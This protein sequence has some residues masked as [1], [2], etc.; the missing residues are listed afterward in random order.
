[1]SARPIS[2]TWSSRWI[3]PPADAAQKIRATSPVNGENRRREI[4]YAEQERVGRR[5]AKAGRPG[6]AGLAFQARPV[7][8]IMPVQQLLIGSIRSRQCAIHLPP[9]IRRPAPKQAQRRATWRAPTAAA[10]A[11]CSAWRWSSCAAA[12][13]A[14]KKSRDERETFAR[15]AKST[16]ASANTAPNK[17]LPM[18]P[19][20]SRKQ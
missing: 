3:N 7:A 18:L 1:M 16:A 8:A 5:S 2:I 10:T 13:M 17:S 9:L 15:K 11:G 19:A 4:L 14:A 12:T 20:C 6:N